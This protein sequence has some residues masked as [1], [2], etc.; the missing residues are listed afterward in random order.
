[1]RRDLGFFYKFK[2]INLLWFIIL[3]WDIYLREIKILCLLKDLYKNIFR[4]FF[5]NSLN[6]K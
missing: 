1:M 5:Y 4:S 6:W 2:Y 3:F